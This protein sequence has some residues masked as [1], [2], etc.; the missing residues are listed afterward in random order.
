MHLIDRLLLDYYE[1]RCNRIHE[2][3]PLLPSASQ[4]NSHLSVELAEHGYSVALSHMGA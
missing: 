4:F 3:I 1:E 2:E